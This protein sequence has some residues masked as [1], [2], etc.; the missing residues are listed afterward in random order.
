WWVAQGPGRVTSREWQHVAV[1][2]SHGYFH[3]FW[4]GQPHLSKACKGT[5]FIPCPSNLFLGVRKNPHHDR[6]FDAEIRAFRLSSTA[7]Y[8]A[9]FVPPTTFDKASDTLALL[10]FSAGKG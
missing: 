2:K 4:N 5:T 10:D 3:V 8:Q 9:N 7:L 1:S 6:N